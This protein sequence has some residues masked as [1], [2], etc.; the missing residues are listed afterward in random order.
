[1]SPLA[2]SLVVLAC[3]S[4]GLGIGMAL[5]RGPARGHLDHDAREVLKL[6]MGLIAT[7]SAL[8]LGLL[9]A[10]SKGSYDVQA[11]AVRELAADLLLLDRMMMVYGPEATDVRARLRLL[12][13]EL[14]DR[15]DSGATSPGLVRDHMEGFYT[16]LVGLAPRTESQRDLK[17]RALA[18]V[19]DLGRTRLRMIT[20]G[21]GSVPAPFLV[22]LGSWLVVLF[23]GYGLIAP[24]N[25][26]VS[27]ALAICAV[28][29]AG[30]LFLVLELDRPLGGLM[31]VPTTPLRDAILQLGG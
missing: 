31:H 27:V 14:A 1:V 18:T 19:P 26:T 2:V 7:L 22:V 13:G 8:V 29:V 11:G 28:S 3:I 16:G 20:Q 12:A 23:V 10:A 9:V 4:A 15:I 30:A 5:G 25:A 21:G 17:D 24:R 6:G